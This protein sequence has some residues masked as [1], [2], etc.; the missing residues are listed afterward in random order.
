VS[1]ENLTTKERMFAQAWDKLPT[2]IMRMKEITASAKLVMAFLIG[3]V[4][5]GEKGRGRCFPGIETIALNTGLGSA[6]VKRAIV[7][8]REVRD[9]RKKVVEG[10]EV[11]S[12][13][14]EGGDDSLIH[15]RRMGFAQVNSYELRFPAW[16][17]EL[18][19]D[20]D[21]FASAAIGPKMIPHSDQN[22]PSFGSKRSLIQLKMIP[23]AENITEQKNSE[24]LTAPPL[25]G[26]ENPKI[27]RLQN[28]SPRSAG[29]RVPGSTRGEPCG[30]SR[31]AA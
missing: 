29:G 23:E 8:L 19:G 31:R 18:Y 3:C 21:A 16:I 20:D 25:S 17:T 7:E 24:N 22:D 6:T 2:A 30:N 5:G 10:A 11:G 26:A 4:R 13:D 27:P 15:Y 14:G 1:T 28:P 9:P 12:A